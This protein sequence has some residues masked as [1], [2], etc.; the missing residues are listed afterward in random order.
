MITTK[1]FY[2]PHSNLLSQEFPMVKA[3][4]LH[5]NWNTSIEDEISWIIYTCHIFY[6]SGF[7]KL[8]LHLLISTIP[9]KVPLRVAKG[10]SKKATKDTSSRKPTSSKLPTML[11]KEVY[12]SNMQRQIHF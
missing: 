5:D 7:L 4:Q 3:H 10:W 9:K 12:L 11:H 2:L 1:L 6:L 8:L